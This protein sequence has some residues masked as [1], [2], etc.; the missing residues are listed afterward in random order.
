MEGEREGEKVVVMK[1]MSGE[2]NVPA[3]NWDSCAGTSVI[4]LTGVG[5]REFDIRIVVGDGDGTG[6][7]VCGSDKSSV[8]GVPDGMVEVA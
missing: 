8:N 3:E 2:V 7:E 5:G 4:S 1:T 6:G